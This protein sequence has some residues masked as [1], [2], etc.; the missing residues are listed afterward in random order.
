MVYEILLVISI[1]VIIL[2][3]F[4][5]VLLVKIKAP[6][7]K[8][9]QKYLMISL[10]IAEIA[11]AA[12]AAGLSMLK[13]LDIDNDFFID[14]NYGLFWPMYM[15]IMILIT[16]D[17]LLEFKLNIKYP[18]Y[19]TPKKTVVT[20]TAAFAVFT[21]V[22]CIFILNRLKSWNYPVNKI[23]S[24]YVY[25]PVQGF[26]L[27][28]AG[29]TYCT[30]FLKLK[31]N[32]RERKKNAQNVN[33]IKKKK[34]VKIFMPSFIILT[35]VLFSVIPGLITSIKFHYFDNQG[36]GVLITIAVLFPFGWLF[37]PI[38]YIFSLKSVRKKIRIFYQ[39]F[40]Y[41]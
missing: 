5:L 11:L 14:L 1:F 20:I 18:I 39:N 33:C 36:T 23:V 8:G 37:D 2:H 16:I 24:I 15:T 12:S 30:I 32:E 17:R 25:V 22:F 38:I 26:F 7:L 29:Y 41:P 34:T 27:V 21:T 10:S 35:F 4:T 13:I 40:R 28:L 31:K 19:W 6:N 9:S 3:A